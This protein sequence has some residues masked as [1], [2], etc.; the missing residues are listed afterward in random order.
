LPIQGKRKKIIAMTFLLI[1]M[2]FLLKHKF[3]EQLAGYL[4]KNGEITNLRENKAWF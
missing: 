3:M 1:A 4:D 2:I